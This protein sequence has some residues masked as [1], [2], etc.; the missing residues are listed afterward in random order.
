M[1]TSPARTRLGL[2]LRVVDVRD[3]GDAAQRMLL[4]EIQN[5]EKD[6]VSVIVKARSSL[7]NRGG[8]SGS[9]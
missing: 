3:Q 6:V 8:V 2:F 1:R 9:K 4:L 5:K 7:Q